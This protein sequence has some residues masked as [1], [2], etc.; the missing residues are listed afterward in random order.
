MIL[1]SSSGRLPSSAFWWHCH[2]KVNDDLPLPLSDSITFSF[3]FFLSGTF[4]CGWKIFPWAL[5]R[6]II[7]I[8]LLLLSLYSPLLFP[9]YCLFFPPHTHDFGLILLAHSLTNP[10]KVMISTLS[11]MLTFAP[12]CIFR[13]VLYCAACM[14]T[15]VVFLLVLPWSLAL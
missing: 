2:S 5:R 1:Q 12:A 7:P 10:S 14:D 4:D 13:L 9:L 8:Y 15:P 3:L 11:F 6:W